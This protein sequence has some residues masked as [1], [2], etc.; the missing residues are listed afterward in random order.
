MT[1][2]KISSLRKKEEEDASLS[3]TGPADLAEE[4]LAGSD[5]EQESD[6]ERA[7]SNLIHD[8]GEVEMGA[9]PRSVRFSTREGAA[10]VKTGDILK[11]I[12]LPELEKAVRKVLTLATPLEKV[13]VKRGSHLIFTLKETFLR[14]ISLSSV[15]R[16]REIVHN[17]RKTPL[18]WFGF[19]L[20]IIY[21]CC[22]IVLKFFIVF[23]FHCFVT[24]IQTT[25]FT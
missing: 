23:I 16:L 14:S 15:Q 7:H 24:E 12:G 2:V 3:I 13:T 19:G 4:D 22:H 1:K 6:D 11:H 21:R 18:N 20:E 9:A 25:L 5:D 8:I 10:E 17:Y